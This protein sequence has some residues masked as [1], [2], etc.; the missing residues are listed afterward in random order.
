MQVIYNGKPQKQTGKRT[1]QV[2]LP[3]ADKSFFRAAGYYPIQRTITP[4]HFEFLVNSERQRIGR[5]RHR[6]QE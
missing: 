6:L 4:L 3:H 2:H 1:F 5:R